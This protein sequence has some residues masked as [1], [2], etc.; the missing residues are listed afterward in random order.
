MKRM[1]RNTF[2]L[3]IFSPRILLIYLTALF[4][5]KDRAIQAS[6][7][8]VTHVAK[9]VVKLFIPEIASARDFDQL[10]TKMKSKMWIWRLLYD[11]KITEDT[12][13]AFQIRLDN[14]PVCEVFS[15]AGLSK[16]NPFVCQGDW[17]FAAENRDKW[18][19]DRKHQIGTGDSYCDHT[20][21]RLA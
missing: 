6:S 11:V 12:N 1:I 21:R 9:K 2:T 10:P 17:A 18:T 19:F 20:Y 7:A 8:A 16:L 13:D 14:C 5:G 4:I 15:F 3:I